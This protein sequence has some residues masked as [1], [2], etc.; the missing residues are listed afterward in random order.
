HHLETV[1]CRRENR[2]KGPHATKP[3]GG[4]K[5]SSGSVRLAR[6][7]LS[8]NTHDVGSRRGDR[9]HFLERPAPRTI[10]IVPPRDVK[11]TGAIEEIEY[12]RIALFECM[13]GVGASRTNV[14][15]A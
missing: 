11:I 1:R 12:C 8:C 10:G 3:Q 13:Q 15:G 4:E 6:A 14:V 9:L 2:S 7:R 5:C